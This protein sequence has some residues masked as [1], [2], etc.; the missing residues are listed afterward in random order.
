MRKNIAFIFYMY[1]LH[2]YTNAH[3]EEV[4]AGILFKLAVK[5]RKGKNRQ[6]S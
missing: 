3:N 1:I 2:I 4:R 5:F 6:K